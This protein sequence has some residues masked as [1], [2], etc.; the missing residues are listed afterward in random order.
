MI[1][2]E[3][4]VVTYVCEICETSYDT[5]KAAL[6]CEKQPVTHDKGVKVGDEVLVTYGDGVGKNGK[7]KGISICDKQAGHY[8]WKRYW[9]TPE[10]VVDVDNGTRCLF[11]DGYD[12][13]DGAKHG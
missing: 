5:E 10:L 2:K 13:I 12:V 1:K 8:A 6:N 4:V 9:H 3:T 11:W 7:V